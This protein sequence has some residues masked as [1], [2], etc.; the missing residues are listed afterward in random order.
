MSDSLP[1]LNLTARWLA[2]VYFRVILRREALDAG[3]ALTTSRGEVMPLAL[4]RVEGE[5]LI[6]CGRL[7][8]SWADG[9][10]RE[11]VLHDAGG[12]ALTRPSRMRFPEADHDREIHGVLELVQPIRG[13]IAVTG[14]AMD[15]L[16]PTRRL[17]VSLAIDDRVV[18]ATQACGER[19]DLAEIGF[20]DGRH[21]FRF[22][23]FGPVAQLGAS[24][25][26]RTPNRR[27]AVNSPYPL[28]SA[29]T[30]ARHTVRAEFKGSD[31]AVHFDAALPQALAAGSE[32]LRIARVLLNRAETGG[33]VNAAD[34]R[35]FAQA[36][37]HLGR[38]LPHFPASPIPAGDA[39]GDRQDPGI[40][41]IAA[42][43]LA[44]GIS[45][46]AT[47]VV[48][49]PADH[50]GTSS[51]ATLR[52]AAAQGGADILLLQEA[53]TTIAAEAAGAL[54]RA[55]ATNE[56]VWAAAARAEQPDGK[57]PGHGTWAGAAG[58]A[59]AAATRAMAFV[60]PGVVAVPRAALAQALEGIL[61]PA[62]GMLWREL[63]QAIRAAGGLALEVPVAKAQLPFMA[64]QA[65]IPTPA[66]L[67]P[68]D[69]RGGLVA[70]AVQA[71]PGANSFALFEL[72]RRR[73][74]AFAMAGLRPEVFC[75]SATPAASVR[76]WRAAG[77]P[78]HIGDGIGPERLEVTL[79]RT[80]DHC[81]VI[82]AAGQPVEGEAALR[83][84]NMRVVVERLSGPAGAGE[85]ASAT[86][87]LPTLAELPA[88]A[89]ARIL[90]SGQVPSRGW[91]LDQAADAPA[92]LALLDPG[93][94][95]RSE[96]DAAEEGW[97]L[98][99]RHPREIGRMALA[100]SPA[101]AV[102]LALHA[103][104][105]GLLVA[106][107]APDIV[108]ALGAIGLT[109]DLLDGPA[110]P[111]GAALQ[112]RRLAQRAAVLRHCRLEAAAAQLTALAEDAFA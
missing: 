21:G 41:D 96:G 40:P 109:G 80:P 12:T 31:V 47:E 57:A 49:L 84:E 100:V 8:P 107:G 78:V 10:E 19:P 98:L 24:L 18:A 104:E 15:W 76:A 2:L 58:L 43:A 69:W 23:L 103:A 50:A 26:V 48:T 105:R 82:A 7:Q 6:L 79:L 27:H 5:A 25:T 81:H 20:S 65:G 44:A 29:D 13:G 22:E 1:V 54:L 35:H 73:A 30:A 93:M 75:A 3:T 32:T 71:L 63:G 88:P 39:P 83:R 51:L 87:L 106:C 70:L 72:V 108:L 67:G 34:L 102:P 92:S 38:V 33:Q 94:V 97:S 90:R 42:C 91:A 46:F 56:L 53:G 37:E 59:P 14:W 85:V 17:M 28:V 9:E 55:V 68:R 16:D 61:E 62:P 111:T 4:E 11:A 86:L 101:M 99:H 60:A 36:I 110:S 89:L 112:A 77:L 74:I 52:R 64:P 45:G 95:P 66:P